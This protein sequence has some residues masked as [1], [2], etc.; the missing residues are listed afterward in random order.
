MWRFTAAEERRYD[1]LG[2]FAPEI[3]HPEPRFA[4]APRRRYLLSAASRYCRWRDGAD[5]RRQAL[6]QGDARLIELA[7]VRDLCPAAIRSERA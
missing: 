1:H 5:P 4:S 3:P 2:G 7:M 6:S